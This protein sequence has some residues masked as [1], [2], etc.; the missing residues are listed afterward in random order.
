MHGDIGQAAVVAGMH[1]CDDVSYHYWPPESGS[2]P[3][4]SVRYATLPCHGKGVAGYHYSHYDGGWDDAHAHL[5][6]PRLMNL[7]VIL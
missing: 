6:R 3:D 2:D 1:Q 4:D 7:A 5:L